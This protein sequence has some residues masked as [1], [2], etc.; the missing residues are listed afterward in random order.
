M[1]TMKTKITLALLTIG[2]AALVGNTQETGAPPPND[3]VP[4]LRDGPAGPDGPDGPRPRPHRP[5]S[6]LMWTLDAN[7]DGTID[8]KE[9][10]NAPDSL[11]KLDRNGDGKL[12]EN[13]LHPSPV[14]VRN[15]PAA[16]DDQRKPRK[17]E[18]AGPGGPVPRVNRP[19]SLLMWALDGNRDSTIDA[20]E[21]ANAS[22]SLKKLDKNG[23][24]KLTA[25]ELHGAPPIKKDGPKPTS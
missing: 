9:I 24:G 18:P 19:A 12:T 11:R 22:A 10:A 25:D 7:R 17:E 3:Q 16:S 21:I 15:G 4:P 14:E 20:D 8:A 23:D 5:A 13:E 6:L 1:K 2:G